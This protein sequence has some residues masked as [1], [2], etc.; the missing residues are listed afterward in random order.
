M[1]HQRQH[2]VAFF[3]TCWSIFSLLMA[4]FVFFSL[5]C[6]TS[7][8]NRPNEEKNVQTHNIRFV[9]PC[10]NEN[11]HPHFLFIPFFFLDTT[12]AWRV[13]VVFCLERHG[14]ICILNSFLFCWTHYRVHDFEGIQKL[15]AKVQLNSEKLI[16][17]ESTDKAV[18]SSRFDGAYG[19][20]FFFWRMKPTSNKHMRIKIHIFYP[21][22]SEIEAKITWCIFIHS[23]H[24]FNAIWTRS[25]HHH[26]F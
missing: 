8:F 2:F 4:N 19:F 22:H 14:F 12:C 10:W 11:N 17:D 1:Q 3:P 26:H 23:T 15:K 6:F 20:I 9:H 18:G 21:M 25:N 13:Y 7:V 5:F 24:N 16:P